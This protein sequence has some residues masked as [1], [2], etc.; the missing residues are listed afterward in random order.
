MTKKIFI[1]LFLYLFVVV[2]VNAHVLN[3]NTLD[4]SVVV[5]EETLN[6]KVFLRE[7]KNGE[8][9]QVHMTLLKNPN[10]V[11]LSYSNFYNGVWEYITPEL[12]ASICT[13]SRM[14]EIV[15][16]AGGSPNVIDVFTERT[17]LHLSCANGLTDNV[18]LLIAQGA[19]VNAV[20][21]YGKKPL[22][23]AII[24]NR[25]DVFVILANNNKIDL[26]NNNKYNGKS[27]MH[28]IIESD[29]VANKTNFIKV[30]LSKNIDI[31]AEDF[32]GVTPLML[33]AK[34][35][36]KDIV[37]FLLDNGADKTIADKLGF[38]AYDYAVDGDIKKLLED[39]T[40]SKD[41]ISN[42]NNSV[43]N[44]DKPNKPNPIQIDIL[45]Y[46]NSLE[47][48]GAEIKNS[49]TNVSE[50]ADSNNADVKKE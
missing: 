14:L 18:E 48:A 8:I 43:Q 2:A 33:A 11:K 6:V 41:N 15:L 24:Y 4:E 7:I 38:T 34:D 21:I 23:Y 44:T 19:N 26:A 28:N 27:I 10:F 16:R 40:V 9:Q 3:Y 32:N 49:D 13:N 31:N 20:D 17:P 45:D 25:F 47:E 42:N 30:L 46:G 5:N 12:A 36:K 29:L 22:D 37:Q 39:Y 35:G 1:L 50:E